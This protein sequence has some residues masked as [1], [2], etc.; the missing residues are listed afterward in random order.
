[1]FTLALEGAMMSYNP[2]KWHVCLVT[3]QKGKSFYVVRK[4]CFFYWVY[5]DAD[6]D[7]HTWPL[8]Y[9]WARIYSHEKAIRLWEIKQKPKYTVKKIHPCLQ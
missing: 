6:G 5:A 2:F 4:L 1:M 7:N 3:D 9:E 8:H